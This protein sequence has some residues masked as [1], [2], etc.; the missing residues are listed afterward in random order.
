MLG[1]KVYVYTS[2]DHLYTYKVTRVLRHQYVLPDIWSLKG[3]QV[4][5]QTSEGPYGTYNKLM[6][7]AQRISVTTASHADAHPI[8]RAHR[9]QPVLI[10]G[11]SRPAG[12]FS[13]TG[14][15]AV[16]ERYRHGS[17]H[18]EPFAFTRRARAKDEPRR[19]Q[20]DGAHRHQADGGQ[21]GD[22]RL[23]GAGRQQE[24][25]ERDRVAP[26]L[27]EPPDGAIPASHHER[28]ALDQEEADAGPQGRAPAP[29]HGTRPDVAQGRQLRGRPRSVDQAPCPG[30]ATEC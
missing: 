4:W 21:D 30:A 24:L 28:P 27:L 10:A 14:D 3:Q 2:D 7:V 25:E 23:R 17:W 29:G 20:H 8:A 5:L 12:A 13:G 11:P 15:G 26:A 9:V 1:M 22:G 18:H 16:A 6:V 19:S